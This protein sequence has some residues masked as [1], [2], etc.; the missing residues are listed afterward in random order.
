MSRHDANTRMLLV[1]TAADALG[2]GVVSTLPSLLDPRDGVRRLDHDLPDRS[3]ILRREPARR[4]AP[5]R[6]G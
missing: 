4:S 6:A 3:R 1:D 5:G 2:E